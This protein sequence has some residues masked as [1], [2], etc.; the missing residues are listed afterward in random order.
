MLDMFEWFQSGPYQTSIFYMQEF[1]SF[2][3]V[4]PFST[5]SVS[6]LIYHGVTFY[7]IAAYFSDHNALFFHLTYMTS[8]QLLL[9][10][11]PVLQ[12]C[13]LGL[14]STGFE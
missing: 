1:L 10:N 5:V 9:I 2:R 7:L 8:Y 13:Q 3:E 4:P 6:W 11:A 12:I 14:I